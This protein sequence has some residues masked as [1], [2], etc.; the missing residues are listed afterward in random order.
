MAPYGCPGPSANGTDEQVTVQMAQLDRQLLLERTVPERDDVPTVRLS[1]V[2]DEVAEDPRAPARTVAE[3]RVNRVLH[4]GAWGVL[5]VAPVF[6][7]S[8]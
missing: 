2:C 8:C 5:L 1:I 7:L 4:F 6:T 3:M